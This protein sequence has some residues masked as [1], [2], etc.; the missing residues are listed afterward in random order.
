MFIHFSKAWWPFRCGVLKCSCVLLM[1]IFW[2]PWITLLLQSIMRQGSSTVP[3]TKL[4]LLIVLIPFQ[5][6]TCLNGPFCTF[7]AQPCL[8]SQASHLWT[9][10]W[11]FKTFFLCEWPFVSDATYFIPMSYSVDFIMLV[12]C[13]CGCVY[14]QT[15]THAVYNYNANRKTHL[16]YRSAKCR[17]CHFTFF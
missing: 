7:T 15:H 2:D 4:W 13:V 5:R 16:H 12:V 17:S 10:A 1:L 9:W 8:S 14:T 6:F 3:T 11:H